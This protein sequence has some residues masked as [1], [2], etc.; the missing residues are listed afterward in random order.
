MKGENTRAHAK[1][2]RRVKIQQLK[3]R[4]DLDRA[5]LIR[6]SQVVSQ[7][8]GKVVQ[9]PVARGD[10]VHEGAPVSCCIA[11]RART[12]PTATPAS[13]SRSIFV[14]RARARIDLADPV[15]VSPATVKREEHGFIKG[16]VVGVWDSRTQDGDGGCA[17]HIRTSPRPSSSGTCPGA[18]CACTSN[19]PMPGSRHGRSECG[20]IQQRKPFPLSSPRAPAQPLKTGTMCQA[21]IVVSKAQADPADPALDQESPW[22]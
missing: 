19:S 5:K 14:P 9:V 8:H 21:A 1:L 4:L 3:T 22:D 10:L 11:R 18:C 16:S 15:E 12:G 2:E 17:R 20:R 13:T 6:T 7:V